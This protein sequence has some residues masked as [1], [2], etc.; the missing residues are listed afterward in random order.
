MAGP[1]QLYTVNAGREYFAMIPR[2][3]PLFLRILVRATILRFGGPAGPVDGPAIFNDCSGGQ[4]A[5]AC[6][7][8]QA[9]NCTD[10]EFGAHIKFTSLSTSCIDTKLII[11]QQSPLCVLRLPVYRSLFPTQKA[12]SSHA[13]SIARL[14]SR[15]LPS[16][17]HSAGA[18]SLKP[19]PSPP[20]QRST[21][22]R[23]PACAAPA[24]CASRRGRERTPS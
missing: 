16:S 14:A 9:K 5:V 11:M 1:S 23:A 22:R 19:V 8:F 4:V 17:L 20:M 21:A 24:G 18:W 7:Q 6:Q 13:A 12:L 3:E 2:C 10:V 15:S